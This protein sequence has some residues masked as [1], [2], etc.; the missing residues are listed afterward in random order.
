LADDT[1][2]LRTLLPSPRVAEKRGRNPSAT[3]CRFDR[4]IRA[5]VVGKRFEGLFMAARMARIA[6]RKD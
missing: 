4:I 1:T 5:F 6:L 3:T 2:T